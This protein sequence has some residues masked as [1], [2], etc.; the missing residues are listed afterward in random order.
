MDVSDLRLSFDE[1]RR[2]TTPND[3]GVGIDFGTTNSA[4]AIFDG[5]RLTVVPLERVSTIMPS[6][7][8]IDTEFAVFTGHEAIAR[9]VDSN[10]G[11]R[12]EFRAEVLGEGRSSTGQIDGETGLPSTAD[13]AMIYGQEVEDAGMPGR[14]FHGIKRMLGSADNARVMIFGKPFRLVALI[15]PIL[16]RIRTT[17]A[18]ALGARSASHACI[19]FPVRFEGADHENDRRALQRLGES[20]AHAGVSEQS[21][22][23]EPIAAAI[24]H[25]HA[26]PQAGD[27]RALAV[28]FG[29]GTL[30]LCIIRCRGESLEVEAVHGVG[31]GGNRIDQAVFRALLFPL[32]GE[33]QTWKRVVEG[34]EVETI[35]PFWQYEERLLNWQVTYTLNQN[36]YTT[37]LLDQ[38]GKGPEAKPFERLYHL[39][40][41]NLGFE[42]FRAIRALKETLSTDTVAVLDIPEIDVHVELTRAGFEA[43]IADEIALFERT[44]DETLAQARLEGGDI[45]LVLRTGGSLLI[46]AFRRILEDRFPGRLVEQDPF[47][48]VAAGL[49]IA[50]YFLIGSKIQV[51]GKGVAKSAGR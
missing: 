17:V 30:D 38:L 39:I 9:Y 1:S 21:F 29:G 14:L 26:H 48:S 32:L 37:P 4:A 11:R 41:Q 46:P 5:E 31:L 44:V 45:D 3:V 19:G 22:C 8:Y 18:A 34:R 24:E 12:V 35:F 27:R 43:M 47:T 23:P 36:R 50:D 13:T 16:L 15:T 49:A 25:L 6:A 20:Y 7:S 51:G 2:R 40:A 42:I 10:R 28:D 33:G